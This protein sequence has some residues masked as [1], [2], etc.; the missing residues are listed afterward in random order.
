M[1]DSLLAAKLLNHPTAQAN[2]TWSSLWVLMM[3]LYIVTT[4]EVATS[5]SIAPF[6]RTVATLAC[7]V[8]GVGC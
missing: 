1:G 6:I 7:L 3:V 8:K 4:M 5:A 2:S